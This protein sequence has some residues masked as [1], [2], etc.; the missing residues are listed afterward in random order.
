MTMRKEII[1]LV[2]IFALCITTA[3][4]AA[5]TEGEKTGSL[6]A[7][8]NQ[9]TV[10]ELTTDRPIVYYRLLVD[11][12]IKDQNQIYEGFSN[13]LYLAATKGASGLGAGAY[14]HM[15]I[16]NSNCMLV[17]PTFKMGPDNN[18]QSTIEYTYP[19]RNCSISDWVT[20]YKVTISENGKTVRGLEVQINGA[21]QAG[22][23]Y[24][25]Q[26]VGS[27]DP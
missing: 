19:D 25:P 11:G 1:M 24:P 15:K 3:A 21:Q 13:H 12:Q 18:M 9:V 26:G 6:I 23:A 10:L 8:I 5:N 20:I 17:D 4:I 14:I 2:T 27:A 22:P 7:K 16:G